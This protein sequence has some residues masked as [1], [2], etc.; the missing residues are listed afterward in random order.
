MG[1][2]IIA[3]WLQVTAKDFRVLF[4]NRFLLLIYLSVVL[5]LVLFSLFIR[6]YIG[7]TMFAYFGKEYYYPSLPNYMIYC[8]IFSVTIFMMSQGAVSITNETKHGTADRMKIMNMPYGAM[9]LGK[10]F[11]YYLSAVI[12]VFI[13]NASIYFLFYN[14]QM[15]ELYKMWSVGNIIQFVFVWPLFM[16]ILAGIFYGLVQLFKGKRG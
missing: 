8:V 7:P 14:F 10:M 13:F 6:F 9:V 5:G 2:N 12:Y 16:V 15:E 4:K 3:G 1:K 11:F